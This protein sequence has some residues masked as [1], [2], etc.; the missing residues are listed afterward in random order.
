MRV[1]AFDSTS[2]VASP[3][4][5]DDNYDDETDDHCFSIAKIITVTDVVRS[6]I[7]GC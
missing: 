2:R 1:F 4:Y 6:E 5:R 3:S 7:N